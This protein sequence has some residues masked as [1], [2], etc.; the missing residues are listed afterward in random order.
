MTTTAAAT[1]TQ[2]AA[3]TDTSA[4]AMATTTWRKRLTAPDGVEHRQ[5]GEID[6]DGHGDG[7]RGSLCPEVGHL[8]SRV[9]GD[10]ES[11]PEGRDGGEDEVVAVA[12]AEHRPQRAVVADVRLALEVRP[13]QREH[14]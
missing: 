11:R 8:V 5:R 9:R 3:R 13:P 2:V 14:E 10:P 12:P 4:M 7:R 6:R 1:P